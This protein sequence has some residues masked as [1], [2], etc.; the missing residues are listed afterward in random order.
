M[1][2]EWDERKNKANIRKHGIS[3]EEASTVFDDF[4]LRT[5]PDPA[6]SERENRFLA[7]GLS[8]KFRLLLVCHC[9]RSGDIVRIFSARKPTRDEMKLYP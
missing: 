4:R 3:F 1:R 6:H 8:F 9:Y 5:L 2:F 7:I